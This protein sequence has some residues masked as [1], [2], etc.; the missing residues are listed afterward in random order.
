MLWGNEVG[1]HGEIKLDVMGKEDLCDGEW[2]L[3]A[4]GR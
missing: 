4:M 3:N 1:Y 2:K